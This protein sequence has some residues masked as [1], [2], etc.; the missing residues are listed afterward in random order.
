MLNLL[1][2]CG[3]LSTDPVPV[4]VYCNQP[5]AHVH[6]QIIKV[7]LLTILDWH[8]AL[9]L[10]IITIAVRILGCCVKAFFA[11]DSFID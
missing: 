10:F 1:S 6:S 5:A 7:M 3:Y 8:L 2:L 4:R 11:A 9:V